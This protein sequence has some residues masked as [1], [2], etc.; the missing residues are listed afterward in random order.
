VK[1]NGERFQGSTFAVH[2]SRF[3][4]TSWQAFAT[5]TPL[6]RPIGPI[7]RLG[8]IQAK[9]LARKS[10]PNGVRTQ[11][12]TANGERLNCAR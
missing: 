5:D 1:V 2:G 12:I 8:P 9:P 7:G 10:L 3:A 6:N 4:V 11:R